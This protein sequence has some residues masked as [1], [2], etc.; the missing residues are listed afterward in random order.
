MAEEMNTTMPEGP[1]MTDEDIAKL[2]AERK[3]AAEAELAPYKAAAAARKQ[4]TAII[5]EHD[6]CLAEL[7]YE[8]SLKDVE[9][10]K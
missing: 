3:A 4:N 5:A 1:Q 8:I 10:D 6:D 7:M 2:D 9:G